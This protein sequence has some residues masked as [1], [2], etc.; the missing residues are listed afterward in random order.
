M[1]LLATDL[2]AIEDQ[3]DVIVA[4]GGPAGSAAAIAA[5]R[6]GC[7]VLVVDRGIHPRPKVCGCCLASAGIKVLAQLGASSVLNQAQPLSTVRLECG[8]Q[9]IHMRRE[10]GVAIGRNEL[11]GSQLVSS[12]S[13]AP[14][15]AAR[16]AQ[17]TASIVVVPIPDRT[18]TTHRPRFSADSAAS[19]A[20]TMHCAPK[21]FAHSVMRSGRA[22]AAVFTPILSAPESMSRAASATAR[23]P[24]P[25]VSGIEST[26]RTRATVCAAVARPSG[27]A[28]MSSSVISSAPSAS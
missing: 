7:S 21:R 1:N 20:M 25:T 19:M 18:L 4:G 5:A 12:T 16:H 28:E 15:S 6:A 24:P 8:D 27:V 22:T 11:D 9:T 13:P 2:T 26:R 3:F 23:T 10:G 17:A 14:S